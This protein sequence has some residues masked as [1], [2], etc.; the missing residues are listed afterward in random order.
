[1]KKA[2][3]YVLW[4]VLAAAALT[5]ATLG[6]SAQAT[7]NS[8]TITANGVRML[9]LWGNADGSGYV[10]LIPIGGHAAAEPSYYMMYG[11]SSSDFSTNDSGQGFIPASAV[12]VSNSSIIK[13][14]VVIKLNVDTCTLAATEFQTTDGA[15]GTV[16]VTATEV[17]GFYY[18]TNGTTTT[19]VGKFREVSSGTTQNANATGGGNEIGFEFSPADI[20]FINIDQFSGVS[21]QITRP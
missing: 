5:V 2:G 21:V 11:A 17:P 1:M 7:P 18:T 20:F 10:Q 8:T 19:V 13:G 9:A 4:G 12:S 16:G 6:V 15:C 3:V 14:N